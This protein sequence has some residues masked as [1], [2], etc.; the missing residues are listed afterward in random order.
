MTLVFTNDG[1]VYSGVVAGEND[2]Q[3][4][5][6][7]ANVA[8]PITINKSQIDDREL[9]D[10]SMMPEGLFENLTDPEVIDLVTYLRSLE[11]VLM[12]DA[13]NR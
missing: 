8:E 1:Q 3:L 10:L 7:I 6:R 11:P 5:L 2:R 12:Q 13:A 9:T 4:Q